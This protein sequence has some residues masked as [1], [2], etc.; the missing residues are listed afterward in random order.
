MSDL[1]FPLAALP[2]LACIACAACDDRP[3][4]SVRTLAARDLGR[5]ETSAKI[6][7][8]DGGYSALAFGRSV[9]LYGD[10]ILASPGDDGGTWR[11]NTM[12]HTADLDA[13]DGLTGFT[14]RA[15]PGGGPIEFIPRTDE[16]AAFNRDHA[17]DADGQCRKTP[18]GAR[19]A[20]W[21]TALVSDSP[22]NRALAFYLKIYGEPGEWN[23]HSEGY[24]VATWAGLDQPPVRPHIAARPDLDP[25]LLFGRDEPAFGSAALVEGDDLYVY[26]CEGGFTKPCKL[27]RVPLAEVLDRTK[28]RY[29]DGTTFSP[30]LGAAKSLFDGHTMLSVHASPAAGGFL[31]VYSRPLDDHIYLRTAPRPEGPWSGEALAVTTMKSA[32]GSATYGGMAHAEL[33]REGGRFEYVSYYRSTGPFAGEVRMVEVELQSAGK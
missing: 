29:W 9:W 16:E 20:L 18:C 2:L 3:P 6:R 28:W 15:D 25:T 31:A 27:A 24:S 8:R 14:D 30:D 1:R 22:R 32:D 7:G 12:S 5:L 19:Y 23:F 10:S 13:R 11:N 4:P 21:P 26:G 17:Q 33:A